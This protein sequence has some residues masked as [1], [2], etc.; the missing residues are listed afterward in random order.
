MSDGYT[1]AE[2]S[3]GQ[4]TLI[5]WT[6]LPTLL[7]RAAWPAVLAD[8]PFDQWSAAALA[9]ALRYAGMSAGPDDDGRAL[10]EL[11]GA[12]GRA[13]NA[14]ASALPAEMVEDLALTLAVAL[15]SAQT[16]SNRAAQRRL[17]AGVFARLAA[18]GDTTPDRAALYTAMVDAA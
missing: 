4:S 8:G 14:H 12:V 15:P 16:D 5:A 13:L 10:T 1:L 7:D 17:A 18:R 6:L 9:G 3:E 11:A 2:L